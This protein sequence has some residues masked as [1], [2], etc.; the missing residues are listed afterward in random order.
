MSARK[1]ERDRH[2][3][4]EGNTARKLQ[5]VEDVQERTNPLLEKKIQRRKNKHLKYKISLV[6]VFVMTLCACILYL[7][8]EL[9]VSSQKTQ[10]TNIE[11]QYRQLRNENEIL[12]AYLTPE[13]NLEEIYEIATTEL[14][15]INPNN[16]QVI[17]Y[18]NEVGSFMNQYAQIPA[19][20]QNE[21]NIT[22]I[23]GFISKG[24]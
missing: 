17:Y 20:E 23:I 24:W 8:T 11:S 15:M 12:T 16:N 13:W 19:E 5:V 9:K 4:V 10:V 14:G 7:Q 21:T 2:Y 6:A 18:D 3:Y 22:N 1:L